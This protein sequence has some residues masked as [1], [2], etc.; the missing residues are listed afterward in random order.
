MHSSPRPVQS[1]NITNGRYRQMRNESVMNGGI[2]LIIIAV[3]LAIPAQMVLPFPYGLG[4]VLLLV[5]VGIIGF[6]KSRNSRERYAEEVVTY[7]TEED[8]DE[9]PKKDKESWDGI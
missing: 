1:A 5:I 4:A 6:V 7:E 3:V 2:I 9:E 8:E